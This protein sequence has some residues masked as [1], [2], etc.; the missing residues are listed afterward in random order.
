MTDEDD[1]NTG[2]MPGLMMHCS[3]VKYS[4]HRCKLPWDSEERGLFMVHFYFFDG[5]FF[6]VGVKQTV[7][8]RTVQC[9]RRYSTVL[10]ST[11]R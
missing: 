4:Y 10:Y 8:F 6:C 1:A 5:R 7:V 9:N 3:P 11:V 2:L